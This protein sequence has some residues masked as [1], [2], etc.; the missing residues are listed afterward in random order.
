MHTEPDTPYVA[1]PGDVLVELPHT[2][3]AATRGA[4]DARARAVIPTP[5]S[6]SLHA[7]DPRLVLDA[8]HCAVVDDSGLAT[9]WA[10]RQAA[11]AAGVELVVVDA[12]PALAAWLVTERQPP[13]PLAFRVE[14][15]ELDPLDDDGDG[16]DD[17]ESDAPGE[18]SEPGVLRLDDAAR[19]RLSRKRRR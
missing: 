2:L 15:S 9:L 8:Q 12:A 5:T 11:H 17:A 3:T 1:L 14:P 7:P 16:A 13:M 18:P 10:L 6:L 19:R 4:F